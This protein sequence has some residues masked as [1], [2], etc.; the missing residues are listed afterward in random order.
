VY[1]LWRRSKFLFVALLFMVSEMFFLAFLL[2]TASAAEDVFRSTTYELQTGEFTGNNYTLSLNNDLSTNYY[3]MISGPAADTATRAVNIDQ[4]RVTADPHSNF[5]TST[6]ANQLQLTRAASTSNWIGSMTVVEC[7]FDCA[8]SGFQLTEVLEVSLPAGSANT[9]QSQ[10]ETLS[11]TH[12]ASTVPFGGR[13]GGGM[14]SASNDANAYGTTLGVKITKT[15]TDQLTFERYGAES[16]APAAATFTTY[17]IDFG[18]SWTVQNVNVAGTNGGIGLNSTTHYNSAGIIPVNRNESWVWGGGYSGDDGLDGSA[19]SQVVTLGN[20]VTQNSSESIVSVG[21]ETGPRAPGRNVQ[22]YVMSNPSLAVDHV[23][24][25]RGDQG[26][27]SGFQE[28]NIAVDAATGAE[29]YDNAA[30]DVQTTEGY[31]API[32]YHTSSGNGQAYSR[33]GAWGT[34]IN[35]DTNLN[36]YRAYSGQNVTGWAQ[37]MDFS[38]F[39]FSNS[40]IEQNSFRFRDDAIDLNTSG[41]WL[42]AENTAITGVNKNSPIRL[43]MQVTNTGTTP[44]DAARNYELQ[45]TSPPTQHAPCTSAVGWIGIEDS[46]NDGFAMSS[47]IHMDPDGELTTTPML[48][49]PLSYAYVSGQGRDVLDTTTAIGPIG[50]SSF[51]E[52][53]YSLTATDESVTG[54]RYCFRLF[55]RLNTVELNSY[56]SYPELEIAKNDIDYIGLGEAGSFSSEIDG[57]WTT[58]SFI[59]TYTTPVVVGTTNSVSANNALVFEVDN[60]TATSADMRVCRSRGSTANGCGSQPSETV[61]YLVIDASVAAITP[62]IEAGTVDMAGEFDTTQPITNYPT[63][64]PSVPYLFANVNTVNDTESP[65]EI[66]VRDVTT[67]SFTSGLC[68]HLQGN[69]D[70]CDG[71]HVTETVGWVAIDPTNAPF[72]EE[73]DIGVE[74][75]G[76]STWTPIAFSP[77]FSETPI[78]IVE[79]QTDTGGQDVTIDEADLITTGSASV[80]YCEIDAENFCDAHNNDDVAWF[81]IE[82]GEIKNTLRLDQEGFRYYENANSLTPTTPLGAENT[83]ISNVDNGD[84]TRLRVAIQHGE[85]EI[86][87]ASDFSIKMQFKEGSSCSA[88]GT[89]ID[90][91]AQ[92][93]GA[94]WRGFDNATPTDGAT[95]PSSLLDG[96]SNIVQTYEEQN[97]SAPNVNTIPLAETSEWDFVIEN[98]NAPT[99]T[100]YCFRA[101]TSNDEAINYSRYPRLT[102]ATGFVNLPPNT[103]TSLNQQKTSTSAIPTGNPTNETTVVFTADATDQNDNDFVEL[104]VEVQ[105]I[106]T[107]FTGTENACGDAETY[108]SDMVSCS[109]TGNALYEKYD[110]NGAG[111]AI[112]D[113]YAD[114]NYPNNPASSQTISGGLLESPIDIDENFGGRLSALICPP[115]S[116]DYTFWISADDGAELRLSN[117]INP[118]NAATVA[119]VPGWSA[120][121]EWDKFPE[122][123][124]ALVTLEAG[125]YYYIEGNYKEGGG[126]DHVQIGWTLPDA[127]LQRPISG[128]NYSLPTES[129][130]VSLVPGVTPQV[131]VAVSGLNNSS[132]YH[133]QARTRDSFGL[134][135]VWESFGGNTETEIDF[136]VDTIA[137]DAVIFDGLSPGAD[138]EFNGGELDQIDANWER[139]DGSAPSEVSGLRLWLDGSDVN[140]NGTDPV[141]GSAIT[142]WTDKSGAANDISGTG[143]A[144]FSAAEQAVSFSDD[145][146]PFNDTY[147]RAGGNNNAQTIFSVV[148]GNATDNTNHVWYETT[149]PRIAPAEDGI[150]GAGTALTSNNDWSTHIVDKKMITLDY[151]SGGTSTGWLGRNQ[152]Y[153]FS[154]TQAFAD[155]QQLVIGDDTTGGNQL[156]S[157]EYV[158]E[159]VIFNQDV[160]QSDREDLWEHLECKWDLKDCSVTYDYA[161]GTSPGGL[162]VQSWVSAGSSTSVSA[163]SLALVTGPIYYVSLRVTDVAGNQTIVSSDGQQVAPT[164]TFSTGSVGVSF[165]NLN[166]ENNFTDTKTTTVTTSTNARNGYSIRGY[167]SGSLESALLNTID[168][169]DG[170]TY[171]DP[172]TWE[173]GDIG[174]GYTSS[175]MLVQGVNKFNSATCPGGGSGGPCFA[176]FAIAGPGDIIAD[177]PGEVVGSAITNEQFT[178][179]HRVTASGAQERGTYQT[180]LILQA[181]ATY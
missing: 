172:D 20:G 11:N 151:N 128:S 177:N 10:S 17:V 55:D 30:T 155:S 9:L 103:P 157:G 142:T 125:Q 130:S 94:V 180:T 15:A 135:S 98:N 117:D 152:E 116:G 110:A 33:V 82:P 124:S 93:S 178:I 45:F 134:Y 32:F 52:L 1:R 101:V 92:G 109:P 102:T 160:S 85:S 13:F 84:V 91:G 170:G 2:P 150:L 167:T 24:K 161:I 137:P 141:D 61:G 164:I 114:P 35:S 175:D 36:Y 29:I 148:Q 121:D 115:Q 62:G 113:L 144:V 63:A 16:R 5:S 14:S 64:F 70:A 120:P 4:V 75:I 51:T 138:I 26:A 12:S 99:F 136:Y 48:A 83:A 89:W 78:V 147:D 67:T 86:V 3:V 25:T 8:A 44:E 131:S 59:G 107:A 140:G 119:S 133:W 122:Q 42:A 19:V 104:C 39:S 50:A 28:L 146:L 149:T 80:R 40:V 145:P 156:E 43:R 21:S 76:N 60:V 34:R 181:I 95:L 111:T 53:E 37:V 159:V 57:G 22:V 179:T 166:I 162:D 173:P 7:L 46:G 154:E 49:N 71:S 81:A 96:G 169:F 123:E 165:S 105:E 171:E 168:Q 47:S 106:G 74:S 118:A 31:R 54:K 127:T 41:G 100:Q 18:S 129:S 139:V 6:S 88:A 174:Y 126:G 66:L 38:N 56:V 79:S 97:D 23:F 143:A 112:G 69:D 108:S 72:S 176:P 132:D 58:V 27:S 153:Q 65:T 90:V 68:E 158:H 163:T 87:P 77:V 73:Y